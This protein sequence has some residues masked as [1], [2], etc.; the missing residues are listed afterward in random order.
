MFGRR[1]IKRAQTEAELHP[2][3][4]RF[5]AMFQRLER[6]HGVTHYLAHNMTVTPR[7]LDE[8]PDVV[9]ACRAMGFRMLSFQP[10][11]YIG[12]EARW[13]EAYR[14]FSTDEV[15]RRVEEG[16][17]A[18]LHFNAEQV[19]DV[20][21]NRTAHGLYAGDRYATLL[22][23]DD[24]RDARALH[25]FIAAF[26]G[27]DFD[28]GSAGLRAVRATRAIARHPAVLRSGA[29]WALRLVRRLGG[30]R[31]IRRAAP[32]GDDL[33]HARVHG[34]ARGQARLGA[35]AARRAVRRPGGPRHPGAPAGLLL[36]DG[37]PRVRHARPGLR[38][39]RR[40]RPAG[41]PAPQEL[42]PLRP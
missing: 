34:R 27:M 38:P 16:A 14:A 6:E 3:R 9:R 33:R 5:C 42:L 21:C 13:K 18:R 29:P 12:N 39:A 41:E 37:A 20:R 25:D 15:W 31:A 28:D 2:Y 40:A 22:D 17:G 23:E 19:G 24:P 36:R 35:A 30:V 1:G 4:E 10:A 32:A 26:G 7:N 11:A 8:I